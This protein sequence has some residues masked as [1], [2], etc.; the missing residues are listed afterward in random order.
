MHGVVVEML[1]V[2][3]WR[4]VYGVVVDMLLVDVWRCG[5]DVTGRCIALRWRCYW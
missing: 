1:L 3:A 4:C 5:G 2:D